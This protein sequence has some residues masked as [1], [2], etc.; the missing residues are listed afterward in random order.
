M[1]LIEKTESNRITLSLIKM[2][3]HSVLFDIEI[4]YKPSIKMLIKI[5]VLF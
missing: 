5:T 3:K 1:N 4:N 2:K